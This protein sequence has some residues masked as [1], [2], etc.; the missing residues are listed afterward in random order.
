MCWNLGIDCCSVVTALID[1]K[2]FYAV[3]ANILPTV[4]SNTFKVDKIS[5]FPR[6]AVK[7]VDDRL[8]DRFGD[9]FEIFVYIYSSTLQVSELVLRKD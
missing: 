7:R 5:G 6:L 9:E 1:E 8:A 3:N 2:A 4:R